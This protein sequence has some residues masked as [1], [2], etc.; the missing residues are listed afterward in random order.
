MRD[1]DEEEK[2]FDPEEDSTRQAK[3]VN[4]TEEQCEAPVPAGLAPPSSADD[5]NSPAV[6]NPGVFNP[7]ESSDSSS[8]EEMGPQPPAPGESESEEEGPQ[9]PPPPPPPLQQDYMDTDSD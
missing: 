9:P 3:A 2:G 6:N 8:E 4:G 5:E 7:T 1:Y